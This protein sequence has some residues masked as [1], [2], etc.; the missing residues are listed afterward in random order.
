MTKR[1]LEMKEFISSHKSKSQSITEGSH[2]RNLEAEA[3]TEAMEKCCLLVCTPVASSA[4]FLTH[5]RLPSQEWNYYSQWA[6]TT[7]ISH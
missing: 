3:D 4:C 1:N 5:P 7:Y 2:G 6:R